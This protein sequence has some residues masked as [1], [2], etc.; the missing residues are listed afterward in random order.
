MI[1]CRHNEFQSGNSRCF[2][3]GTLPFKAFLRQTNYD[4]TFWSWNLRVGFGSCIFLLLREYFS[5]GCCA[6]IPKTYRALINTIHMKF[7]PLY[8]IANV[9]ANKACCKLYAKENF[10]N[11]KYMF[12]LQAHSTDCK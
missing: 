10:T 3:M 2:S 4:S 11:S 5:I 1:L 7:R 8:N 9:G 12:L 6:G